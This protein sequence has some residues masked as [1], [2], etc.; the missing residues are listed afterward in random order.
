MHNVQ[1]LEE[2]GDQLSRRQLMA[3][4]IEKWPELEDPKQWGDS[5][6]L[7][8]HNHIL[9]AE[10]LQ[11]LPGFAEFLK[12]QEDRRAARGVTNAELREVKFRRLLQQLESIV[13]AQKY[14]IVASPKW[15]RNTAQF[16]RLKKVFSENHNFEAY[17]TYAD[18]EFQQCQLRRA[19]SELNVALGKSAIK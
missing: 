1:V 18:R 11:Q 8:E 13:L 5:A 19:S 12:G 6:L 14:S 2:A 10:E 9:F 15:L 17:V 3:S 7:A 16:W 4:I